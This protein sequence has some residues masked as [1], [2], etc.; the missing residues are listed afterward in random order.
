MIHTA[1]Y[2]GLPNVLLEALA[3][4]KYIISTNCPTGPSEI[5]SNGKGGGL[6][7]VNDYRSIAKKVLEFSNNKKI[8]K[9][10]NHASK[11]LKR[12]NYSNNLDK[13]L[14]LVNNFIN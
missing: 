8:N 10:V 13:Y 12:F 9:K 3:L 4:K 11:A 2:E 7:K 14:R 5:L 1:I 6:V